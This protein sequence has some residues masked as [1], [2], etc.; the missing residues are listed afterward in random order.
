MSIF[1]I[2]RVYRGSRVDR[3]V[4]IADKGRDVEAVEAAY[5]RE[6]PAVSYINIEIAE[7]VQGFEPFSILHRAGQTGSIFDE[8]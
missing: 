4:R 7:T 5:M 8:A 1:L 6:H 2:E 3:T